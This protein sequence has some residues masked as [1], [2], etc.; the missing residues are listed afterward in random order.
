ML[1]VLARWETND[2][3]NHL[4]HIVWLILTPNTCVFVANTF[5]NSHLHD[6][7]FDFANTIILVCIILVLSP[8][9][10][11]GPSGGKWYVNAWTMHRSVGQGLASSCVCVGELLPGWSQ[12]PPWEGPA[13]LPAERTFCLHACYVFC[14][15]YWCYKMRPAQCSLYSMDMLCQ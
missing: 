7:C 9:G 15:G 8:P 11:T 2:L 6:M 1:S 4:G 13:Y 10:L 12:I 5:S 14:V 3:L